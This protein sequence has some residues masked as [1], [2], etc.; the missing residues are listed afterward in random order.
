MVRE[1]NTGSAASWAKGNY[2]A[3]ELKSRAAELNFL[4]SST[5]GIRCFWDWGGEKCQAEVWSSKDRTLG[6][7]CLYLHGAGQ[8]SFWMFLDLFW[9]R[10]RH[11]DYLYPAFGMGL[12]GGNLPLELVHLLFQSYWLGYKGLCEL[13]LSKG[14]K[15][16]ELFIWRKIFLCGLNVLDAD[17]WSSCLFQDLLRSYFCAAGA[18]TFPICIDCS[19]HLLAAWL[20]PD[21]AVTGQ[22]FGVVTWSKRLGKAQITEAGLGKSLGFSGMLLALRISSKFLFYTDAEVFEGPRCYHFLDLWV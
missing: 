11:S 19:L 9:S 17:G 15:W 22:G 2:S 13:C 5:L 4:L 12:D 3:L 14:W 1:L 10:V 8:L 20:A 16:N 18:G 21:L 7:Y 6:K